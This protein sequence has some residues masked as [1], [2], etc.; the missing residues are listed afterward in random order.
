MTDPTTPIINNQVRQ[1]WNTYIDWL[2]NKGMAG[3]PDLDKNGL[4]Y[5]MLEQFRRENPMTVLRKEI[6][7]PLQTA[8]SYRLFYY[9]CLS[10]NPLT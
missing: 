9:S 3:H 8:C 5:E 7:T 6:I 4:G 1:E 10:F 2:R